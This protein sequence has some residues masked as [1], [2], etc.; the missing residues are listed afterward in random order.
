MPDAE[1][2][3]AEMRSNRL[4]FI[5]ALAHHAARRDAAKALVE[6][7]AQNQF[8]NESNPDVREKLR[9]LIDKVI[10]YP[11]ADGGRP[12]IEVEGD[13]AKTLTIAKIAPNKEGGKSPLNSLISSIKE[14]PG[15]ERPWGVGG[16]APN[17]PSKM[18][19]TTPG[20]GHQRTVIAEHVHAGAGLEDADF[21]EW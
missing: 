3:L 15:A 6:D 17:L 5:Q 2:D 21:G 13:L 14:A 7:R 8:A 4:A 12:K 11:P 9:A 10:I 18:L 1:L 16:K 20:E 19:P